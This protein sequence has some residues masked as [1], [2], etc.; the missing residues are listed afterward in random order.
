MRVLMCFLPAGVLLFAQGVSA[1]MQPHRA[2]YVL[3]LGAAANAPRVGTA[4]QDLTVDCD[5]WHLKRDIKGEIP[6]SPTWKLNVASMLDSDERRSGDDL[7]YATARYKFRMAPSARCAARCGVR[8]AS[9]ALRSCR[10][11]ALRRFCCL[12]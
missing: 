12:R 8:T 10:L 7:R 2:E 1:E 9:C 3:R 6:I 5:G 4:T 11:K